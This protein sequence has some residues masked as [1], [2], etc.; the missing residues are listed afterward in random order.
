LRL[1]DALRL[2][3][4]RTHAGEEPRRDTMTTDQGVFDAEGAANA[5]A[6]GPALSPRQRRHRLRQ[7]FSIAWQL[8]RLDIFRRYTKTL[9]GIVWAVLSPL[10]MACVIGV[11]F[12]QLFGADAR[13][14][15]PHLFISLTLWNFFVGCVDGGAIA[16]IAL[17]AYPLR[18]VLAALFTLLVTLGVVV[19]IVEVLRGSLGMAW[20]LVFPGLLAWAAFGL[21]VACLTGLLNTAV[22]DVQYIQTVLVQ[23]LFYATP[24]I[25]PEKLL[26]GQHL[27]W[28]LTLNPLHHLIAIIRIPIMHNEVPSLS[29]YVAVGLSLAVLGAVTRWAVRKAA[30]RVVFWL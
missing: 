9:L 27:R 2:T 28:A 21:F 6:T 14:F 26:V 16:F 29:H 12:S 30:H 22:R 7:S 13:D 1:R 17:Y 4:T 3:G 25:Y 23:I 5:Q 15:L 24:V 10:L 19:V 8:A 20:L 11:V 18:M